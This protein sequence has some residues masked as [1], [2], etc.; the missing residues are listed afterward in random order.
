MLEK[1]VGGTLC[2]LLCEL[3]ICGRD[4]EEEEGLEVILGKDKNS[5]CRMYSRALLH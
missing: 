1:I 4:V 3:G 2:F 5:A